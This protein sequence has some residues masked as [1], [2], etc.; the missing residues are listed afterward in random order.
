MNYGIC[1]QAVV[2]VRIQP[3]DQQEM[4]NQLL[5]GDLVV[6]KGQVKDWLLIETFDDQYE[7]WIDLKQI[8]IVENELFNKLILSDR[9]Y[10]KSLS[11]EVYNDKNEKLIL[12]R[13]A[14]LPFYKDNLF[15]INGKQ[16]PFIK[17]VLLPDGTFQDDKL[18]E[19]SKTYLGSP[20]LWG[21]RTPFGIDCSG[22]VQVVYKM[23][24][25]FLPRDSSQQA[26]HGETVNFINEALAGDLA[27][28]SNE[29]DAIVHVG[30]LLDNSHIIHASGCVRVDKIDHHGI[31]NVETNK[32]THQLRIIKRIAN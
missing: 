21:G 17:E 5:F 18:I 30:I 24:G 7:G 12:T 2:P 9:T 13:G 31:F 20:Y 25:F 10:V 26:K 29:E 4:C 19:L 8:S 28:F 23:F 15:T 22:F 6:I 3:G 27:F 11:E 1:D 32:Y 14:F 16:F